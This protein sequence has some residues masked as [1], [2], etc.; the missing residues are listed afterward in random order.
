MSL[1][2]LFLIFLALR[3][4]VRVAQKIKSRLAST[5][6][7]NVPDKWLSRAVIH[8]ITAFFMYSHRSKAVTKYSL[9]IL[10]YAEQRRRL[11]KSWKTKSYKD[12]QSRR[13]PALNRRVNVFVTALYNV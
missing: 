1:A 12:E 10:L 4:S 9:R 2:A 5:K 13:C 11:F 7:S 3:T 6:K 8:V